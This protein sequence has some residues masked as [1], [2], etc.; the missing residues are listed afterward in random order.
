[1]IHRAGRTVL[2]LVLAWFMLIILAL[3][4]LS[5]SA[6]A[7]SDSD[8]LPSAD[9]GAQMAPDAPASGTLTPVP[10]S[11]DEPANVQHQA[12]VAGYA[13]GTFRPDRKL[14]RAE[15][16]AFLARAVKREEAGSAPDFADVD[17]DYWA[18]DAIDESVRMHL[19]A[20]LPGG[21]FAPEQP[22]TFGELTIV[23]GRLLGSDTEA[24]SMMNDRSA[25]VHDTRDTVSRAEFVV[26]LN[27]ALR[28]GPLS[29]AP[30]QW[31]DVPASREEYG[32][33]QEASISHVYDPTPDES[34]QWGVSAW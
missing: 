5:P 31:S 9:G 33:I 10:P 3:P 21:V 22:V 30:Q 4:S 1:M 19:M 13:D 25:T 26:W 27:R 11:D 16:A 20:G 7:A 8:A 15:L 23:F 32:D 28:R 6:R 29:G 2:C 34:E 17:E 14:S 24:A 18:H 12:Y